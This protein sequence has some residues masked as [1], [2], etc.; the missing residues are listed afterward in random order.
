MKRVLITGATTGMGCATAKY[1]Y[2]HGWN[3][4]GCGRHEE[5]GIKLVSDCRAS[6]GKGEI[7][8][9]C[10]DVSKKEDIQMLYNKVMEVMG[11]VD[12]VINN[13]GARNAG[14]L[15]N[16]SVEDWDYM[17]NVDIKSIF[18]LSK[19]VVPYMIENGG[20][21]IMNL[22]SISGVLADWKTPLYCAA[23][24]AVVNITRAMALDYAKY[25]IRVNAMCPGAVNTPMYE[26]NTPEIAQEYID[27]NPLWS[28]YGEVCPPEAVAEYIYFISEKARYVDGAHLRITGAADVKTGQ[29]TEKVI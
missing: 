22:A 17:M 21:S 10:C 3:V 29:P 11:G 8:F 15:H 27:T 9:V 1:Y 19:L 12:T 24:G 16:V 13:A 4:V 5:K 14:L 20:G 7:T 25:N 28:V 18:L 6:E 2:K 26:A 23:K